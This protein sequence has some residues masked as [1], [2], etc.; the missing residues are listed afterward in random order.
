MFFCNQKNQKFW[1]TEPEHCRWQMKRRRRA[2]Q[3]QG[4][5]RAAAWQKAYVSNG[6]F[7]NPLKRCHSAQKKDP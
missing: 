5:M 7:P 1:G 2:V 4:L 6:R 3:K